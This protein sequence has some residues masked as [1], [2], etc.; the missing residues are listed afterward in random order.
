[1][2]VQVESRIQVIAIVGITMR[3]T[4]HPLNLTCMQ[5]LRQYK[6]RLYKFCKAM[7][8]EDGESTRKFE[9]LEDELSDGRED[10]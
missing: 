10:S 1:M 5:D 6:R 8:R 2:N 7:I 9:K 4:T 3:V